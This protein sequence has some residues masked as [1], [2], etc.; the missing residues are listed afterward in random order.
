MA[1]LK[2]T[3]PRNPSD[4][5]SPSDPDLRSARSRKRSRS[6][7]RLASTPP[8][9]STI[10][11]LSHDGRGIADVAGKTTFIENALPSE[12]VTW[13]LL[14]PHRR[15]NEG[16]A[17]EILEPSPDRVQPKCI[18]FEQCGGCQLQHLSSE[19]QLALKQ[20][21]LLEQLRHFG[22][23]QPETILSPLTG[24]QYGYRR[25]ARLGVRHVIKKDKVLIGFREKR[26]GKIADLTRCEVLH[27][28]V[29]ELITPLQILITQLKAHQ[30]IP[31]IE[32]AIGDDNTALVFR[33]LEPLIESDIEKLID[34]A[35]KYSIYLYL[36]PQDAQSVHLLWPAQKDTKPS[37]ETGTQSNAQMNTPT[38]A[39]TDMQVD[40]HLS[41]SLTK[42]QLEFKFHPLDFTQINADINQKMVNLALELLELK[43]SDIVLDLFC[44]LGNFSLPLAKYVKKVVGVEGSEMMIERAQQNAKNN[45]LTNVEFFVQ[46]LQSTKIEG[47]WLQYAFDKILIDPPRTG[48]LELMTLLPSFLPKRIVY[49]S[50]NPATLARD[51]GLLDKAGFKLISTGIMDM[52][53]HTAHVE[54]IAVLVP[55]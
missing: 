49:V 4:L 12:V 19:A 18:H 25:K 31:Q 30:T 42:H 7:E 39:R 22:G 37:V 45:R 36:Q 38:D 55:K 24:P 41:Y 53:P 50:C 29:G 6:R 15:Y 32:V 48:A 34:F 10:R 51:V 21:V 17:L 9:T 28:T 20:Q 5:Q 14:K 23:V 27:P 3:G 40:L 43:E 33:H 47:P 46:N 1:T 35:K 13:T 26:T 44:G 52:F 16:R 54:S 2:S 11:S 8:T